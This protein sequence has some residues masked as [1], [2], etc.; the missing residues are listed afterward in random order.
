MKV[1]V[2]MMNVPNP[3]V[4]EPGSGGAV[5]DDEQLQKHL[6]KVSRRMKAE[7][8]EYRRQLREKSPD[9]RS[10]MVI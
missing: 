4:S 6:E 2:T 1:R 8:D 3:V 7:G 5:E 9:V 10:K